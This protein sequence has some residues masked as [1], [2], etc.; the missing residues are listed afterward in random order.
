MCTT[1]RGD[2]ED[3]D[4]TPKLLQQKQSEDDKP[5]AKNGKD[6]TT[7]IC[8]IAVGLIGL[9]RLLNGKATT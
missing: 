7:L 3:W 5:E 9:F 1:T 2:G 8:R 6:D 4:G